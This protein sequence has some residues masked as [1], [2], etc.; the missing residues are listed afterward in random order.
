MARL[1]QVAKQVC[2]G[3]GSCRRASRCQTPATPSQ[4]RGPRQ[5]SI[6]ESNAMVDQLERAEVAEEKCA[7]PVLPRPSADA[8]PLRQTDEGSRQD[9]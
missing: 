6:R 5:A 3:G 7:R 9:P 8:D 4:K 2:Q 1:L